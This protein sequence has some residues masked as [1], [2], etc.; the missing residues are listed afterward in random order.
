MMQTMAYSLIALLF[1]RTAIINLVNAH[2]TV[3]NDLKFDH[4]GRHL[5]RGNEAPCPVPPFFAPFPLSDSEA[6]EAI[7]SCPFLLHQQTTGQEIGGCFPMYSIPHWDD[8]NSVSFKIQEFNVEAE[9]PMVFFERKSIFASWEDLVNLSTLNVPDL[10]G[11]I[12]SLNYK[13][14]GIHGEISGANGNAS[15]SAIVI[16]FKEY[17]EENTILLPVGGCEVDSHQS[18]S[19]RKLV[20]KN[21]GDQ[22]EMMMTRRSAFEEACSIQPNNV[23]WNECLEKCYTSIES[24]YIDEIDKLNT[25]RDKRILKNHENKETV[26]GKLL[27]NR[28]SQLS[29]A[30]AR[31]KCK[32]SEQDLGQCFLNIFLDTL[33]AENNYQFEMEESFDRHLD[34]VEAWFQDNRKL[35]CDASTRTALKCRNEC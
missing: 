3:E 6:F 4:R 18:A 17:E 31:C 28:A 27:I 35:V 9:T 20:V 5:L 11:C 19:D 2:E 15:L 24:N 33:V 13:V 29:T 16:S 8:S 34:E 10:G 32:H 7:S 23:E 25:S 26:L 1:V 12:A 22:G 14:E 21:L 30:F